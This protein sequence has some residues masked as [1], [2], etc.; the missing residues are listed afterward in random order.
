M[1]IAV[2]FFFLLQNG[3]SSITMTD[4]QKE[5]YS[6]KVRSKNPSHMNKAADLLHKMKKKTEDLYN[7]LERHNYNAP[8]YKRLLQNQDVRFEEIQPHYQ[9]EAAYSINKGE[10]IG[11]CVYD[12]NK[13]MLDENTMFFV[14]L[15]ELAHIMS[16]KYA[17]DEEFWTNFSKIIK[18]AIDAGLYR[19]QDYSKQEEKFCGHDITNNPYT[20]K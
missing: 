17:H 3:Y 4:I 14:V 16:T 11:I 12:K 1:L 8:E 9:G 13:F 2:A 20:P 10:K 7:Y 15:H 6:Y 19:Y 5:G 18:V